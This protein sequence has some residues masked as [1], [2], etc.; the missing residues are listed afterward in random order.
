MHAIRVDSNQR[1]YVPNKGLLA[2]LS[3]LWRESADLSN[4]FMG[5]LQ[6]FVLIW[7]YNESFFCY[8]VTSFN[9]SHLQKTYFILERKQNLNL[10]SWLIIL[11]NLVRVLKTH[12]VANDF[13]SIAS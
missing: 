7:E 11:L 1:H 13:G 5:L 2:S 8:L 12:Y 6:I 9:A 4:F 3:E 10:N